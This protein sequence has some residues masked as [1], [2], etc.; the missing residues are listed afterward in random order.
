MTLYTQAINIII[1]ASATCVIDV[2]LHDDDN[3]KRKRYTFDLLLARVEIVNNRGAIKKEM[4]I[5]RVFDEDA[6][7]QD[8]RFNEPTSLT[9][10]SG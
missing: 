5:I 7:K 2:N 6:R 1:V 3:D 8:R 10:R 9:P 4:T